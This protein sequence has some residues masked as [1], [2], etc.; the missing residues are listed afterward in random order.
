MSNVV[1]NIKDKAFSINKPHEAHSYRG[2]FF[3]EFPKLGNNW[4]HIS[5]HGGVRSLFEKFSKSKKSSSLKFTPLGKNQENM[6]DNCAK[7]MPKN[8][9]KKLFDKLVTLRRC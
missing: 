7:K 4:G 3:P 8:W 2:A 9:G 5:I 1:E 6:E